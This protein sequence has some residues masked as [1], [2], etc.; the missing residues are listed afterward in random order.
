[1]HEK[2]GNNLGNPSG[3]LSVFIILAIAIFL[4]AVEP[5]PLMEGDSR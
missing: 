3:E 1:M 4:S 5:G 2:R